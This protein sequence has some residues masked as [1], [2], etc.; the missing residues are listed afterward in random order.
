MRFPTFLEVKLNGYT[1]KKENMF[2]FD[3]IRTDEK[4]NISEVAD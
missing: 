4:E 1:W 2:S 3:K